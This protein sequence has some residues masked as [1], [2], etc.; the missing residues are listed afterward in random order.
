MPPI[1]LSA[2]KYW[3]PAAIGLALIGTFFAGVRYESATCEVEKQE[4][5]AEYTQ[6]VQDE[7]DRRHEISVQ[8]EERLAQ[9]RAD[10]RKVIER[11]EVEVVKPIYKDCKV[12]ESGV[13]LLNETVEQLNNNRK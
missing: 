11:V 9:M 8:Y 3:K 13:N 10:S 5:I 12:P 6:M 2:I 1:L 7:V 4:I